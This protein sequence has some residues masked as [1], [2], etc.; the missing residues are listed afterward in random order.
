[1]CGNTICCLD[2]QL[3]FFEKRMN[4]ERC[5]ASSLSKWE[6]MQVILHGLTLNKTTKNISRRCFVHRQTHS[7]S[8]FEFSVRNV[9]KRLDEGSRYFRFC[10][11]PASCNNTL[12]LSLCPRTKDQNQLHA[13]LFVGHTENF[14]N[15]FFMLSEEPKSG[16][17]TKV[18]RW[19]EG[20]EGWMS[21]H[22]IWESL[23][24]ASW[25]FS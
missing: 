6:M 17:I 9:G 11:N 21:I 25:L 1:M 10:C 22:F 20:E 15:Q 4:L 3:A 12:A 16:I 14:S 18:C 5:V 24:L 8:D 19:L 23:W 7:S 13:F 2:F